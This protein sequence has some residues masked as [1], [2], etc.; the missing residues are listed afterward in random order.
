MWINELAMSDCS[1]LISFLFLILFVPLLYKL[2][3][4][5]VMP[6]QVFSSVDFLQF[7]SQI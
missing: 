2:E 6:Y 7:F 3:V 4:R 1:I 5:L